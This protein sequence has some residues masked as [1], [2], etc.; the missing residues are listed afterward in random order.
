VFTHAFFKACLFLGAGSVMHAVG[1]HGDADIRRLG[2]LRKYLPRTH[3]TFLVSCLAIAGVP[4]F[5]G[6]FSKDEILSGA[7]N[8]HAYIPGG[9][10][11]AVFAILVLAATMTAFYMFRLYFL[12]F[13]G[14]YRGGPEHE[15]HGDDHGHHDEHGS[16][17]PHESPPAMTIPLV[18]LGTGAVVVG[19]LWV[20]VLGLFHVH[21]E[22]WVDWL[23]P[24]LAQA[25]EEEH[26][27]SAVITALLCGT[28]AAAVG[29]G[30]A[31]AWYAKPGVDAP[32]LWAERLPKLH[33]LAFDKW[34]V[35]ELYDAT[36]LAGSRALGVVSANVDKVVVD[37]LLTRVTTWTVQGLGFV[38]TRVQSGLVQAYAAVMVGGLLVVTWWFTMP[39]ARIDVPNPPNGDE[40]EFTAKAGLGY[41]YRWDFD[42]DAEFDTDWSSD[43]NA[44]HT[45]S[46]AEFEPGAVVGLESALYGAGVSTTH[47][48]VGQT[49][50]LEPRDLGTTWQRASDNDTPPMV[51]A[52]AEGLL[53]RL[54][55]ARARKDGK[56]ISDETT[57]LKRGD[58]IS[59][60]QAR[61][62]VAGQARATLYVRNAFG[63]ERR[64][65]QKLVLPEITERP[66]LEV[67]G[68]AEARP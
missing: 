55:G 39:H 21:W 33:D 65:S 46:D 38:F 20:G 54:N 31:Y 68:A 40:V 45:Y 41:Q 17:E 56:S 44:S 42:S 67:V 22:P 9:I 19:Y 34:R 8:A 47:L 5:S 25:G 24:A 49:M 3:W 27:A 30:L 2:G 59:I 14:E 61:L 52:T 63:V 36:I 51:E 64:A 1:A 12:T 60:G 28:A 23:A 4:G 37:G 43:V 66:S 13:A 6:F 57:V 53:V 26:A 50:A 7:L 48:A 35:D 62:S 29:I 16:H 58:H 10:G 15:H 18:V 32:R 11:Y